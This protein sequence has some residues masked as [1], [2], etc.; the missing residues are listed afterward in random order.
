M[1]PHGEC[2]ADSSNHGYPWPEK[3]RISDG[4]HLL[5]LSRHLSAHSP[6]SPTPR[7]GEC[8]A[9]PSLQFEDLGGS[10]G[11]LPAVLSVK[12]T[13]PSHGHA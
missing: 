6:G 2:L 11:D 7:D 8:A 10:T 1:L 12:P 9:W 4:M 3:T 5:R 13:E